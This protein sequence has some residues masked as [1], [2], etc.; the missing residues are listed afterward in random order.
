MAKAGNIALIG[1]GGFLGT[2]FREQ[3]HDRYDKIVIMGRSMEIGPLRDNEIYHSIATLSVD[4]VAEIL[5]SEEVGKLVDFSYNTV[6]KSSFDNP[7]SDFSENLYTVIHHLEIVRK[8]PGMSYLYVS[9]GGTVYGN[10]VQQP[11]AETHPNVPLSPYG[12]TKLTSERYVLMYQAIYG[13]N[14][15]IIRPSN[16]YGPGQ[17]PYRGQGFIATAMANGLK[18]ADVPI[19]GDGTHVRDYLYLTDF[20]AA[21]KDVLDHGVN[22]TV[23]N[24]GYG[25]GYT[26]NEVVEQLRGLDGIQ[27][28]AVLNLPN[29]PFDVHYNVLDHGALAGLNGWRP[30]VDLA[31]GLDRTL[32]WMKTY[33][34]QAN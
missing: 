1:G 22:G 28:F 31:E 24:V 25:S 21:V 18:G 8:V 9:S 19:F 11:I 20:C 2:S 29:R 12:I 10:S 27:P 3:F 6:P 16:I 7:I 13:L 15:H 26:I 23:Y 17:R 34:Q 33:L 5:L 4:R 14:V 30:Q 32:A